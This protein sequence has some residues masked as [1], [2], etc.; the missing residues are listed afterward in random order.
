MTGI[1]EDSKIIC[2]NKF[3]SC[4]TCGKTTRVSEK[5]KLRLSLIG[6]K[7]IEKVEIIYYCK[8]CG[9]KINKEMQVKI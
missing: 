3:I 2:G 6:K 7:G 5:Y 4:Y 1:F 9:D 8:K